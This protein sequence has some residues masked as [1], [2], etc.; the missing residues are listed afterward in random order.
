MKIGY[1]TISEAQKT[2]VSAKRTFDGNGKAWDRMCW[3]LLPN[4][5]TITG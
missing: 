3:E 1:E 2:I 4:S 5:K